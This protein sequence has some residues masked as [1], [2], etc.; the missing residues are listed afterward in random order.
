MTIPRSTWLSIA[1]AKAGLLLS[2]LAAPA[3]AQ[4][5][6]PEPLREGEPVEQAANQNEGLSQSARTAD[7]G[8]GEVGQ[9]QTARDGPAM[10]DPLDRIASRIHNRVENR[11]RNRIDRN[12]DPTANA[13]SPYAVA[14]SQTRAARVNGPR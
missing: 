14:D 10:Q 11:V 4:E 9:R 6:P 2:P 13:T 1:T 8:I 5:L 7:T 12:Y 3:I